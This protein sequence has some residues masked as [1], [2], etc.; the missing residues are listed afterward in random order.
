MLAASPLATGSPP[1]TMTIGIVDVAALAAS[2]AGVEQATIRS[3]LSR[4]SSLASSGKR[5]ASPSA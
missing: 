2:A 1:I 3:T 5:V 4:T